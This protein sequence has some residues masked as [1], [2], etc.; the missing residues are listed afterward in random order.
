MRGR[1]PWSSGDVHLCHLLTAGVQVQLV[2]WQAARPPLLQAGTQHAHKA[3]QSQ[4][5]AEILRAKRRL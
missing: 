4:D 3:V 1:D 2:R 5:R